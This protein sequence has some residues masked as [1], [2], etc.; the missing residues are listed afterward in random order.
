MSHDHSKPSGLDAQQIF[1]VVSVS[2]EGR[3]H[4]DPESKVVA[5]VDLTLYFR[6][7]GSLTIHGCSVL[8]EN[9]KPPYVLLPGRKGDRRSFPT[10]AATGEIRR[11]IDQVVLKEYER[12]K[13]AV[14]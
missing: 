2:A 4:T 3:L 7:G 5:F 13:S 1:E 10:V 12:L 11:V 14:E 6:P 8:Q 9:G